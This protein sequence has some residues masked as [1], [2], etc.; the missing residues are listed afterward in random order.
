[1]GFSA[2]T[3]VDD[4]HTMVSRAIRVCKEHV[5]AGFSRNMS[6][7]V[8]DWSIVRHIGRKTKVVSDEHLAHL[9][10][11]SFQNVFKHILTKVQ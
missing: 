1:M 8:E 2:V 4:G 9:T 11:P 10:K 3:V 6:V 7:Y 5:G